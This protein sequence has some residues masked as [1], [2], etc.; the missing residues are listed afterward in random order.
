MV[1]FSSFKQNDAIIYT[2]RKLKRTPMALSDHFP[3][4]N[5]ITISSLLRVGKLLEQKFNQCYDKLIISDTTF[6][7]LLDKP[8]GHITLEINND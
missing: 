5:H 1:R 7:P 8:F 3:Q 6:A 2:T 4:E